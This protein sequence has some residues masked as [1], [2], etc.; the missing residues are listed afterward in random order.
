MPK[1]KIPTFL[2]ILISANMLFSIKALAQEEFYTDYNVT[3]DISEN[4][5]TSIL[6]GITITNKQNDIFATNYELHIRKMNIYDVKASD[7]NGKLEVKTETENDTT[8]LSTK[9]DNPV[10]GKDRSYTWELVY[11]SKDITTKVGEI[12]N[13]NI[14]KVESLDQTKSYNTTLIVPKTMGPK[15][16]VSPHPI[17]IQ[18]ENYRIIY[19]FDKER[20]QNKGITASFGSHQILNFK[21]EYKL[22]NDSAFASYQEITLPSDIKNKQQVAYQQLEPKPL[23]I[24]KDKDGNTLALYKIPPKEFLNIKLIGSAKIS[25]L[26]INPKFGGKIEELPKSLISNY[27][28]AK[29]FWESNADEIKKKADQLFNRNLTVSENA[30]KAYE[31]VIE[32]LEYDF[33]VVQNEEIIR[34]GAL[35][36]LTE[37][38]KWACVEFSDSFIALTRAMGIPSRELNGYAFAQESNLTPL[39]INLKAGDLLHSWAE[40]FDPNFGWVQVDPTWGNTSGID[41][42]TKLDTNHFAFVVKGLDSEYPFP[43][44][45]YKVDGNEKQ[46]EVDVAQNIDEDVFK[47]SF[48]LYE[49]FSINPIQ[50]IKGRNKYIAKNEGNTTAYNFGESSKELLPFATTKIYL[51]KNSREVY[52]EDFAGDGHYYNFSVKKGDPRTSKIST[53][54]IIFSFSLGLLL[55]MMI[56]VSVIQK[57]SLKKALDRLHHL[58]QDQ[59]Q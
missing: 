33:D 26:Q 55:C 3:Y 56:Y 2:L 41:Y 52:Y 34:N 35:K 38:K 39:S 47:V 8:K 32:N 58:R 49:N 9:L 43:A 30:Q 25:G 14:P 29:K 48:S 23:D 59:D 15:I 45:T 42:F 51:P 37:D 18:E 1:L 12:W 13:I 6:N 24:Y 21:L 31:Y 44:G 36:A 17:E 20:L 53:K 28:K 4:G 19:K 57:V 50:W 16:F 10:I 46:V 7:K 5:E 11:K 22:R 54:V 40:Y 27:T